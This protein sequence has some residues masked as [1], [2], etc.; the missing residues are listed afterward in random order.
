MDNKFSR[1]TFDELKDLKSVIS[2]TTRYKIKSFKHP[3][4]DE[5]I[6]KLFRKDHE[7]WLYSNEDCEKYDLKNPTPYQKKEKFSYCQSQIEGKKFCKIQC[8]HCK[9]YYSPLENNLKQ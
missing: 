8:D 2:C 6:Y 4:L 1:V 3:K 7:F 9:L 5:R